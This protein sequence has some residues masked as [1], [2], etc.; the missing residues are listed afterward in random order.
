MPLTWTV[1]AMLKARL[2]A[3][4]RVDLKAAIFPNNWNNRSVGQQFNRVLKRVGLHERDERGQKPRV[5]SFRHYY[6]SRL[7]ASGS[8]PA[9]VRDLLGHESIAVTNRYF[10]IPRSELFSAVAGAFTRTRS[11]HDS[12]GVYRFPAENKE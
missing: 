10:N 1:E 12:S 4:E 7:V 2:Q 5:H 11:V 3:Q 9:T 6:A 8:D